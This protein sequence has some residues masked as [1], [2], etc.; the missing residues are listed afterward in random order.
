MNRFRKRL[1]ENLPTRPLSA[2]A[3]SLLIAA[4]VVPVGWCARADAQPEL[5]V[6]QEVEL[7]HDVYGT[8]RG[9]IVLLTSILIELNV[10][11]FDAC[12]EIERSELTGYR[13]L[14]PAPRPEFKLPIPDNLWVERSYLDTIANQMMRKNFEAVA[15]EL[16]WLRKEVERRKK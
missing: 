16:R 14:K 1:E 11:S 3:L 10:V 15:K 5:R 13:I 7:Y 4:V 2:S 12:Q 8:C 9:E 6:G